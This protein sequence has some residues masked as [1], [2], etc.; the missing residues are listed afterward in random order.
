M[1]NEDKVCTTVAVLLAVAGLTRNGQPISGSSLAVRCG[2]KPR[3]LEVILQKLGRLGFLTSIRGQR[4]GY[5]FPENPQFTLGDVVRAATVPEGPASSESD[6]STAA[7]PLSRAA[8]VVE[9]FISEGRDKVLSH[10]DTIPFS[11]LVEA[12]NASGLSD[13]PEQWIHFVI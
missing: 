2:F 1:I 4:G 3:T 11:K 8:S 10:F 9:T 12:G 7:T 13:E 6:F 5:L